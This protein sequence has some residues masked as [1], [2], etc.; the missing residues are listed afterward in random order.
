M[1]SFLVGLLLVTLAA[2]VVRAGDPAPAAPSGPTDVAVIRSIG[3]DLPKMFSSF[4]E[5]SDIYARRRDDQDKDAVICDYGTYLLEFNNKKVRSAYFWRTWTGPILG[6][7]IGDSREAVT[8]VLGEA[9][10]TFKNK[11]GEITDFGFKMKDYG[12]EIYANFEDG[13]LYRVE[14]EPLD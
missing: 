6:I 9:N 4:G 10:D 7:K 13:K 12:V 1:R 5:P 8:K 2:T 3:L 11:D 14:I